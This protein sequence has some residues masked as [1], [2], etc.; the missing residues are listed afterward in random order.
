[1]GGLLVAEAAVDPHPVTRRIIGVLA[2]DTPYLGMHPHV[3]VSGIAS[4]FAKKNGE[5]N[6]GP[7]QTLVA[8]LPTEK[9]VNDREHVNFVPS[10]DAYPTSGTTTPL[11]SPISNTASFHPSGPRPHSPRPNSPPSALSVPNSSTSIT[12]SLFNSTMSF[13]QKHAD[14]S[15]ARF[16]N[17][18]SDA[19]ISAMTRWV[20]EY[21]EFGF[22]MFDYPGLL[23]RYKRLEQ[24]DGDWVNFWT[25]TGGE[26]SIDSDDEEPSGDGEHD[27]ERPPTPK[28]IARTRK[29]VM[30]SVVYENEFERAM[31]KARD[32]E[33]KRKEADEAKARE[34]EAKERIRQAKEDEK[35]RR[36]EE[37]R[38]EKERKKAMEKQ[39]KERKA[40][41]NT[42]QKS[43]KLRKPKPKSTSDEDDEHS[44]REPPRIS[45]DAAED[46]KVEPSTEGVKSTENLDPRA[47]RPPSPT[48]SDRSEKASISLSRPTSPVPSSRAFSASSCPSRP[49]SPDKD[50]AYHFITLPGKVHSNCKNRWL[51]VRINGVQDEVAAHTG[52]FIRSQNLDYDAFVVRVGNVVK[53]W[54]L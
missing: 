39:E 27:W 6:P 28:K 26:K 7:P 34:R 53:G 48:P 41:E 51:R 17:K 22:A 15:F 29:V 44:L 50:A 12:T 2:F 5:K 35:Q 52:L 47:S 38:Q 49:P 8:G 33:A 54:V 43:A 37:E 19:P 36:K 1:M 45:I 14:E 21:F 13:L 24:W 18:H 4:L 3:V 16:L 11:R 42:N 46:F 32:A 31:K 30:P 40:L 23:D 9:E 10:I 25:V 20:I